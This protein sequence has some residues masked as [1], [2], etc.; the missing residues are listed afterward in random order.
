MA[1]AHLFSNLKNRGWAPKPGDT[2]VTG[3]VFGFFPK[4]QKQIDEFGVLGSKNRFPRRVGG[5]QTKNH[6]K[7][8]WRDFLKTL[9]PGPSDFRVRARG[10]VFGEFNKLAIALTRLR[11]RGSSAWF[12]AHSF[13]VLVLLF[14]IPAFV[15]HE[16]HQH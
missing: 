10:F 12:R 6:Q 13:S 7:L 8:P 1:V 3:R 11:S 16:N 14:Q 2:E 4:F 15:L 5:P 9:S